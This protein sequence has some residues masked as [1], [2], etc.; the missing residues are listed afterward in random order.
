M[1]TT[2]KKT[3][4]HPWLIPAVFVGSLT[5]V[6]ALLI[7]GLRGEL[8]ANP[9]SQALNQL[10]L[11][12]LVFLVAALACTPLKTIFGWTWPL[13]LRRMLGLYSFF[14]ATLHV[15]TYTGLDQFFDWRTIVDDV[16]K[17][18]FIFVGFAA[19][20]LLIPLAVTSTNAAVKR[21][22]YARWKQLHRLA[23]VA[24]I[25]GVIHFT[26]RVKKDVREP[27]LYAIVLGALLL[28]RVVAYARSR[29]SVSVAT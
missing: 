16:T 27:T 21:M 1:K 29:L 4:P 18:K 20:V 3:P 8:G 7:Q 26:W 22:G 28:I 23:Y 25:L 19:L 12:A 5:P 11:M 14:Y 17:R 9:I 24:P 10:G 6:A 13:R 15:S 2:V